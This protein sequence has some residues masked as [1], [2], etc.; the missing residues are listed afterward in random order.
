V[1]VMGDNYRGY[2]INKRGNSISA[3]ATDLLLSKAKE[4]GKQVKTSIIGYSGTTLKDMKGMIDRELVSSGVNDSVAERAQ[5]ATDAWNVNNAQAEVKDALPSRTVNG[6]SVNVVGN[7]PENWKGLYNVEIHL[8]NY[9]GGN[10]IARE[11]RLGEG[12]LIQLLNSGIKS[13]EKYQGAEREIKSVKVMY[14][15]GK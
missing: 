11:N 3:K 14:V 6:V 8:Y 2:E 1:E 5:Q 12:K 13:Y 4:K 9:N 10:V 7:K 15:G